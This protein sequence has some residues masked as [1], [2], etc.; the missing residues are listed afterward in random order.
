MWKIEKI[1]IIYFD[2]FCFDSKKNYD[3]YS[4]KNE[5]NLSKS[6]SISQ[7]FGL[8]YTFWMQLKGIFFLVGDFC[9][10]TTITVNWSMQFYVEK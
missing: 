8:K 6:I 5:T 7:F 2:L 10:N 4:Y 3:E 9:N 1:T